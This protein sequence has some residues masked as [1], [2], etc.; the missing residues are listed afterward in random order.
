VRPLGPRDEA[1]AARVLARAF[2]DNPLNVAVIG[3]GPSRRFRSNHATLRQL[4]P[5][6][7]S[8]GF[9]LG[10]VAGGQLVGALIGTGP[11]GYPLPP[12]S[13]PSR[14]RTVAVQGLRVA[15]RWRQV[16]EVLHEVHPVHPHWYVG[17]VGV[18]PSW[19]GR[20]LGGLLLSRFLASADDR[21]DPVYLE[22]DR[23]E[24]VG[25]YGRA[26]FRVVGTLSLLGARVWRMERPGPL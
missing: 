1:R 9:A 12:P 19:Q 15:G 4:V 25:F 17:V 14:L 23:P 16:F 26:G 2:R 6:G 3:E 5:I 8:H 10:A 18:D 13:L 24:N 20:G 11:G 21:G 22:T 7:R